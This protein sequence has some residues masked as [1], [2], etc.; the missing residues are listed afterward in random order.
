VLPLLVIA[1][2]RGLRLNHFI[3]NPD[4][5]WSVWQTFGTPEQIIRWTPYDW[6]PLYYLS[7]GLWR[8]VVG[9]YPILLRWLSVLAFMVGAACLYRVMRRLRDAW[10]GVMAIL[11]YGGLGY[12]IL[13]STEVRGYALLLGLMPGALWLMLAYFERPNWR[14]GSLL[15]VC[16]TAMF[17]ISFTSAGAFLMLGLYTL[18]AYPRK[19]W[20]WWLPGLILL[21]AALVEV[22][23]KLQLVVGRVEGLRQIALPP[24]LQ[25]LFNLFWYFAG[26]G[27]VLWGLLLM[28]ATGLIFYRQR[29]ISSHTLGLFVWVFL[30]PVLMYALYPVMGFF[31]QRYAWWIMIGLALWIGWGLSYLPK[32]AALGAGAIMLVAMTYPLPISSYSFDFSPI[33]DNMAWLSQ[34]IQVGDVFVRDPHVNCGDPEEWDY[35]IRTYFPNGLSFV[36]DPA[37]HR[38]VWY[39][40]GALPDQTIQNRVSQNRIQPIFVGPPGCAF[41]LYEAPPDEP[42][43]AFANGMRFHGADVMDGDVPWSGPVVRR[44]GETVRLRLWWSVDKAVDRDY[45]VGTYILRD[46]GLLA[47]VNDAPQVTDGPRETSRWQTGRYYVEERVL[48]LPQGGKGDYDVMLAVYY[49]EDGKR[50]AAPGLNEAGLLLLNHLYIKAW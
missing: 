34:H 7:L 15:G 16:L 18:I 17:Y 47:E 9:P 28:A 36:S 50:T 25:G 2:A 3:L 37:G 35:A 26:N 13:L 27:W 38:R 42:G 21:I 30:A 43:T 41:R 19:L 49:W 22:L 29:R 23:Y 31:S 5:V 24:L 48:Q 39:V 1:A 44:R 11:V 20:R 33:S 12:S 10:A 46:N 40:V 4:E 8:G 32:P 6:P 14:V 45:S